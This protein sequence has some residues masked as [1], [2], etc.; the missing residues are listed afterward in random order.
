MQLHPKKECLQNLFLPHVAGESEQF[1]LNWFHPQVV[2]GPTQA[3]G[4]E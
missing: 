3:E 1:V 2:T 4:I